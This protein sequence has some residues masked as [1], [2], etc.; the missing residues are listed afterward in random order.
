MKS[1][2]TIPKSLIPVLW[3]VPQPHK[4]DIKKYQNFIIAR[5]AEKGL[6]TDVQW[7]KK[8]YGVAAIRRVVARSRNVGAKTKNFWKLV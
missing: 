3:D 5:V 4:I 6:W 7:L 1:A 8:T 2:T